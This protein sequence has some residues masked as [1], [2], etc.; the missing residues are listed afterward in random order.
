MYGKIYNI[1]KRKQQAIVRELKKLMHHFPD[2][3]INKNFELILVPKNNTYFMLENIKS[4]RDLQCKVIAYVS[5]PACK[6]L[7]TNLRIYYLQQ[8]NKYF[9]TNFT[10]KEMEIIYTHLGN[11]IN[12]KK[13]IQFIKS[14]YDLNVLN[15]GEK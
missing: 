9:N 1:L 7:D 13:T 2:S 10:E 11:D 6:E 3:F 14:N 5:R 4:I 15:K 8:F 12:R